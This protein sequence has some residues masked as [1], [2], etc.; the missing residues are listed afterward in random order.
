MI[1]P[2]GI[3][4][5]DVKFYSPLNEPFSL[6]GLIYEDNRYLRM[7]RAIAET[8]SE[9]VRNQSQHTTGGRVCFKTNSPYITLSC[10]CYFYWDGWMPVTGTHGFAVSIREGK[11]HFFRGLV[12]PK[13]DT[14][15]SF[16]AIVEMPK[17][18]KE[19]DVII[20]FPINTGVSEVY[21]GLAE[22]AS[23]SKWDGYTYES[24]IVFYGSSITHGASSSMPCN[25]YAAMLSRRFDANYINLAMSGHCK[26]EPQMIDYIASLPMSMFVYDYDHN[27]PTVEYL[28]QTH[29][30]GYLRFREARPDT[31]IILASRPNFDSPVQEG[32]APIRREI[33][34][35]TYEKALAAGD[36]NV[37]YAEGREIYSTFCK[38]GFACD[39]VH[40]NDIGFYHMAN[41]FA[42]YV[43]KYL[44]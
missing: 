32:E 12:A 29:Y 2:E 16:S 42:P 44:K 27:A 8:V 6:Y 34:L 40:P 17:D 9:G 33:V 26:A 25:S 5:P 39:N 19:R 11:E 41:V 10:K 36:K 14:R 4:K 1:I 20:Y 31:P 18:G 37:T 22:G 28:E 23:L 43:E 30:A 7:P 15:S 38:N 13:H 21:I 35:A 24:P 3:N